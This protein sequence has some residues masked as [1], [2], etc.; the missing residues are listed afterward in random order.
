LLAAVMPRAEE[1][2]PS[3]SS[4]L[5]PTACA[6]LLHLGFVA[7]QLGHAKARMEPAVDGSFWQGTL[8]QTLGTS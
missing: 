6:S 4:E 3:I 5:F 7:N 2:Q 1:V 8:P